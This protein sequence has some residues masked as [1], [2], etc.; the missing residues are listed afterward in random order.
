MS[1]PPLHIP[2]FL[3][4]S[5]LHP[6]LGECDNGRNMAG[7]PLEQ[8]VV[9]RA[10]VFFREKFRSVSSLIDIVFVFCSAFMV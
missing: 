9:S 1:M 2:L 10:C 7:A 5:P 4:R 3:L 6:E 8:K